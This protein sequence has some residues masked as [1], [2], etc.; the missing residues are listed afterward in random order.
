VDLLDISDGEMYFERPLPAPVARLIDAAAE[1]YG[2]DDCDAAERCL[3][4]A[5][6]LAPDH[7]T[8]LVALYRFY[9]YRQ[10][11][12]ET[13]A[14]AERCIIA[15]A[16]EV[17]IPDDWRRLDHAYFA[18]AVQQ[19][20]PLTRFLLLALK[21]AGYVL[22]RMNRPAE[23]LERLECIAAFDERNRLGVT[24]LVAWARDA[25]R[26]ARIEARDDNVVSIR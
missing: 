17:G 21:G 20:M 24:E 6:L 8:V 1:Q 10:R 11:Y 15:A 25:T 3:L 19:S 18:H 4:R 5:Q 2:S 22:L 7:L 14:T 23:A 26:R 12:T 9:F 16:R 13:L